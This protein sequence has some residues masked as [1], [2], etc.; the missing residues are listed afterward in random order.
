MN[1][2]KNNIKNRQR[3]LT[4]RLPKVRK[5]I[6]VIFFKYFLVALI[7]LFIIGAG[8]AFGMLK[9]IIDNAPDIDPSDV[10]PEGFS[11]TIY[12]QDGEKL[13]SL[14]DYDSNRIYVTIDKIPK[15]LQNAF[16]A[17]EDERFYDH[18]GIDP[19]GI[20]RAFFV[21]A[22]N[23]FSG[24][25]GFSE[26]ASTLTQQLIKNNVFA[27]YSEPSF[28]V[29]LE[30]KIQ[31][32]YLAVNLEK[33]LT[34]TMSKY[35]AKQQ[36][37][38]YYLNTINLGQS[39]LGVQAAANRYFDKDV[40]ELTLSE[41]AVIAS[42][43]KNPSALDP[44]KH[45]EENAT[46]R[47]TI[48]KR[49]L[50]Q[51]LITK[52]QYNKAMKDQV[53]ERIE[54]V[55][56]KQ[57]DSSFYSYFMDALIVQVIDDLQEQLGYNR[58][59]AY[60][61][62]Y[63]GGL[64]IYATQDSTIQAICDSVISDPNMF[65]QS[66]DV[67]LGY[68]LSIQKKDGTTKNY[69][70]YDV[71]AYL[72]KK[73]GTS[74]SQM[75][76]SSAD[77]AKEAAKEFKA[78]VYH[79]KDGDVLL[80]EKID[81][82]LQPQVSFTLMD[83]KTG[84]VKA[85]VGGRGEKTG[86][87]TLNR[88]TDTT[89]QPGSTFKIVSTYVP[90]LDTAGITLA[91]TFDDAPYT[92]PKTNTS[93]RN[94]NGQYGGLTTVRKAIQN[95]TNIVAAKTM[96]VVTPQVAY[97]YLLNLG[98]TTLVDKQVNADGSIYSDIQYPMSLG[99]LTNGVTNLELTASYAAIANK[100]LYT[101]PV[102]YTKILDHSGNLL[103][104][105]TPQTKQV[106]KDSTAWLLTNAM[107]DVVNYG[108]GTATKLNSVRSAGKT[109]TTSNN[110]DFW[111][112]GYTPYYTASIW[113]GY[114]VNTSFSSGNTHKII[115]KTIMDKVHSQLGLKD[116]EF[117]QSSSITR[118]TICTKSGKLA[119]P[120]LCDRDPRGSTVR[121]EYFAKGT[122][123]TEECDVHVKVTICKESKQPISK[124]CP[125]SDQIS[126]VY[127]IPPENASSLTADAPYYLPTNFQNEVCHIHNI[128]SSSIILPKAEPEQVP[129]TSNE[130]EKQRSHLPLTDS[131]DPDEQIE[132]EE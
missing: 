125:E 49:M 79:P 78:T 80:G 113:Y 104:D 89:R 99:G 103:Y 29:K 50:D 117:P 20:I 88:A 40:S 122:V 6:L 102:L 77:K 71:D 98:F 27:A 15:N 48:L 121:T 14:A 66:S 132:S 84:Y 45:P 120:G 46:R 9:S 25:G 26:G 95:S 83:Q 126:T 18:N 97:N 96:E 57:S 38:E 107:E 22:K 24:D 63:R 67:S 131:L 2:N 54:Q 130:V 60:N 94:A 3:V 123:P 86:N 5:K 116:K 37:L 115:W 58:T 62:L 36:I 13:L 8:T 75:I 106:M 23:L 30:R 100:G 21:G 51:E 127:M 7:A 28:I 55:N 129:D 39:T 124:Y 72:R 59:Q 52:K 90:A 118:A 17:I 34:E 31:E 64:S 44:V 111:F 4:S 41:S 47:A 76:F 110:Y 61:A 92:W 87:L 74:R 73:L 19:R 42:I 105:N 91:T 85:I 93:V 56:N 53:Y 128:A 43:T 11:T 1:Y 16:I 81:T 65:P 10:Q 108:T 112:S 114:D 33:E 12:N 70:E 32:Q 68:R 35:D 82:T 101:K 119:V 109:G 69:S